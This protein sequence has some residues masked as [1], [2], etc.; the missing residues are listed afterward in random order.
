VNRIALSALD[1]SL[2]APDALAQ[3][4][5]CFNTLEC[6]KQANGQLGWSVLSINQVPQGEVFTF[7]PELVVLGLRKGLVTG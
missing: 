4:T 1:P 7:G 2:G 6:H 5:G 3:E